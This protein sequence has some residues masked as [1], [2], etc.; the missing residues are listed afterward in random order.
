MRANGDRTDIHGV[1][2]NYTVKPSLD[3]IIHRK[4]KVLDFAKDFLRKKRKK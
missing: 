2:P 1:I 3:D 4:D